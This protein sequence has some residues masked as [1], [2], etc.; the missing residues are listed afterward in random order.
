[1]NVYS[2]IGNLTADPEIF[3]YGNNET[4]AH[5]TVAVN[6]GKDKTLFVNCTAYGANAKVAVDYFKKGMKIG[7]SGALLP[8][9]YTSKDGTKHKSFGVRVQSQTFCESKK[10]E[11]PG[12]V[13][14]DDDV[15][16]A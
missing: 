14:L 5:Y 8:V 9:E 12:Y 13:S 10:K 15:P 1:M 2:C 6:A 4:G 11:E 3:G 7:I 16:F